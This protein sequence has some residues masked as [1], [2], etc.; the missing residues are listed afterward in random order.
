VQVLDGR[1]K[2]G[3]L[4]AQDSIRL[5]S[6]LTVNLGLRWEFSS[7]WYDEQDRIVTLVPGQ[8]SVQYPTAPKGLVYPGDPGVP[9]T[10]APTRYNNFAARL[11][12]AYSPNWSE[13]V[14]GKLVGGPGKTSIRVSSGMFYTAIQDQT[15]YWI[16]GTVPFG[17]YWSSPGP[18]F[19]EEPFRTRSTG[20]SQGQPFPYI[21][22]A[23][24]SPEAR[25]FDFTPYLP[26]VSTL[27]YNT[28][29]ELPYGIHYNFTIQRQ[30][31]ASMVLSL[32]YVG[33]LGRKLLSISEANGADPAL[34][35]S[36]RGSGVMPGT[37]ECGRFLEDQTFTRADG[38]KIFGTRGPLGP[39]FGT[40]FYEGNWANSTYNSLQA[41]L[42][43]RVGSLSFLLGYTWSKSMDNG[44]FFNDRINFTNHKLSRSLSNF[45][46]T[47]NFIASY[48]YAM[49]FDK[50]FPG[51]PKRLVSGW[52]IAGITRLAT[53]LPVGVLGAF[54]QSL[55]GTSGLDTPNFSPVS[56]QCIRSQD[57]RICTLRG[58][59]PHRRGRGLS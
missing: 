4:F 27:G 58:I 33:T 20:Q 3:S 39:N 19:F 14:L 53:G 18:T 11:G 36:L 55:T 22:P 30:L 51:V 13:G 25:N 50:V 52:D 26:L 21:I 32:G 49:P 38:T 57:D 40:S 43:R 12:I 48:T 45:D 37:L 24:G 35:L 28:Q 7:P 47:H 17:E 46:V 44:S 34:C 42:E 59:Q 10:L 31:S 6:N 15:L 8:Q 29:N 2:Y 23:P 56:C 1:S 41:S 54:D 9:R 5:T 16:L